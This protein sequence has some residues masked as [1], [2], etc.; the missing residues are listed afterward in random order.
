[1]S[2]DEQERL[3][4]LHDHRLLDAPAEDAPEAVVGVAA[5]VAH[6]GHDVGPST[7]RRIV[8]PQHGRVRAGPTPGGGPTVSLTVPGA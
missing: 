1:M 6:A 3:A 4:A 8:E 5:I 7:G 2:I